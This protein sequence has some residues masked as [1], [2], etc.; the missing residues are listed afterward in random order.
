MVVQKVCQE[1]MP[2][3]PAKVTSAWAVAEALGKD[4]GRIRRTADRRFPD[5]HQ[6]QHR[7]PGRGRSQHLVWFHAHLLRLADLTDSGAQFACT[8]VGEGSCR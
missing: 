7:D 1:C 2:M 4:E 3:G 8:R 5:H 6:D